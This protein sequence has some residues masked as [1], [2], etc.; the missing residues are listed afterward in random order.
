M[1]LVSESI[2]KAIEKETKSQ[3]TF[4]KTL[5]SQEKKYGKDYTEEKENVKKS[6]AYYEKFYKKNNNNIKKEAIIYIMVFCHF[7]KENF[8]CRY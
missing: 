7:R 3:Q 5:E 4:L 2:K 1:S 8:R 6:I